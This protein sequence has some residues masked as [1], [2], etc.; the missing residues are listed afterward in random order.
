MPGDLCHGMTDQCG[1][2]STVLGLRVTPLFSS[3]NKGDPRSLER[4]TLHQAFRL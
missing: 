4:N 3:T 1:R 2:T